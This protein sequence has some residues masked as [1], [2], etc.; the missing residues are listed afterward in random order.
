MAYNQCIDVVLDSMKD[1]L[2]EFLTGPDKIDTSGN[3]TSE[4]KQK[5]QYK[6]YGLLL[7]ACK[8]RDKKE[9]AMDQAKKTVSNSSR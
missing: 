8:I 5:E 9:T 6:S 2:R 7:S 4:T 1:K 3:T